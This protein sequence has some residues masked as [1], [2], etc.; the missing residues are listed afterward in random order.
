MRFDPFFLLVFP[1]FLFSIVV[2][3]CAHGFAA[4][5]C[6]DGTAQERGRL[7]LN[8][9]VHI[10]PLGSLVIPGILWLAH[11]PFL[12]GWAKPMPIDRSRLRDP[13]NDTVKVAMAGPA[14]NLLLAVLFAAVVRVTSG[15]APNLEDPAP[16]VLATVGMLAIAGVVWNVSLAIFNLL[17]IPPLDGSWLVTRFMKLRHIIVLHQFRLVGFVVIAALMS[18][19]LVSNLL[20]RIPVRAV[21]GACL[22]LFGVSMRGIPL[23]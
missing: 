6:G 17:P 1:V 19:P 23:G 11:A 18:S 12:M 3:E 10:D 9:I 14:S 21:V 5:R 8:P 2:H 22:G 13:K 7:T 4:L 15:A 20:F 16:G